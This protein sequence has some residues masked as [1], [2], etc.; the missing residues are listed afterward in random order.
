MSSVFDLDSTS[1]QTLIGGV[2]YAFEQAAFTATSPEDLFN[3]LVEQASFDEPH[4]KVMGRFWAREEKA[5]KERLKKK[6]LGAREM[7]GLNYHLNLTMADSQIKRILEPTAIFEFTLNR[8]DESLSTGAATTQGS[9]MGSAAATGF[10]ANPQLEPHSGSGVAAAVNK[11]RPSVA[12]AD[13][14]TSSNTNTNTKFAVE[15]THNELYDWFQQIEQ[16]QHALDAM[17]PN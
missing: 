17:A 9:S 14:G 16:V 6:T 5:F 8:G 10:G 2:C 3:L 11:Q 15:L 12:D 13:T 4:A 7:V 1:L